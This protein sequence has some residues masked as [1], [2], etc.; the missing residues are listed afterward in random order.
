MVCM[1]D[2]IGIDDKDLS[3]IQNLYHDQTP[4][5][6]INN[7]INEFPPIQKRVRQGCELLLDLFSLYREMILKY[8]KDEGYLVIG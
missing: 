7:K 5:V 6:R 3:I 2:Q 8:I 4:A 1:T